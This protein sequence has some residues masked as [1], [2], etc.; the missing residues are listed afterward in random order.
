MV[1]VQGL[2]PNNRMC[3]MP[4]RVCMRAVCLHEQF[5][6]QMLCCLASRTPQFKSGASLDV[7]PIGGGPQGNVTVGEAGL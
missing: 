5:Q 4:E 3:H 6:E 1:V 2:G 7:L